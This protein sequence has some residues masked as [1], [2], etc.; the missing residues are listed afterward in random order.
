MFFNNF[1]LLSPNISLYYNKDKS[2]RH[3]SPLGGLLTIIIFILS[4]YIIIKYILL[5]P[6][7][8][9]SSLLMYRNFGIDTSNNYFNESGLFHFIWIYN[10]ENI[11]N[12]NKMQINNLKKGIIRIFMTYSYDKYDYNSQNLKDNDHWVY[13]TCHNYLNKDD[14]KYDYSFS[15]CIKYYYNSIDK[16]YYSIH[17]NL[18]FKWPYIRDNLTDINNK[19]IFSTFIEKCSNN[20]ILNDIMGDCYPEDK[21]N[22]YLSYFNKIFISFNNYK[23]RIN[24]KEIILKDYSDKIYDNI[25]D[26][27]NSFYSRELTFI[28]FNYEAQTNILAKKLRYNSFMLDGER[29]TKIYNRENNNLLLVYIFHFKQYINEFRKQNNYILEFSYQT[30]GTIILIYI[31]FYILNYFLSERIEIRNFQTFLHDKGSN[32]IQKHIHYER[33][34]VFSSKSNN[35]T[36]ISNEPNE[37]YSSFKSTY[38]QKNDIYNSYNNSKINEHNV[39]IKIEKKDDKTISKKSDKN[40]IIVI[41]N[42]TFMN[43]GN[44]SSNNKFNLNIKN[45]LDNNKSLIINKKIK[46]FDKIDEY[47]KT[48]TYTN[49]VEDSPTKNLH[50]PN[51]KNSKII[52]FSIYSKNRNI[53]DDISEKNEILEHSSKQKIIDTSSISLLN[54]INKTKNLYI[55]NSNYNVL[56]KKEIPLLNC[57]KISETFSPKNNNKIHDNNK[58][59]KENYSQKDFISLIKN[60]PENNKKEKSKKNN[61][62]INLIEKY[63]NFKIGSPIRNIKYRRKSHQARNTFREKDEE[64]IDKN[65]T[66][67]NKNK[68]KTGVFQQPQEKKRERKLSLFSRYSNI[69]NSN[70]NNNKTINLYPCENN[71]Q[72]NLSKN[73]L[74]HYKKVN[75]LHKFMAKKVD[76]EK[77]LPDSESQSKN[78]KKEKKIV[79]KKYVTSTKQNNNLSKIIQNINWS[80][81]IFFNYLCMY[82]KKSNNDVNILN[83]FRCKLLSEEYLYILHF[84]MFIFKNKFGCKTNIEAINL[85]EELYND[86]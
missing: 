70:I 21:I 67:K 42:G 86:Y 64:Y 68:Q 10:D 71:S 53:D 50:I 81:K 80:K 16:K 25:I 78:H 66:Y 27:D 3:L 77:P 83:N 35:Y 41:N 48:Y 73:L 79:T 4:L 65:K 45:V 69:I 33:N 63:N 57:D 52:N 56:P 7:P 49:Q 17:D 29:V 44:A 58:S 8:N 76:K 62:E 22:E 14:L 2:K 13:D 31:I 43:D 60:L 47:N 1:D 59:I 9:S 32:T 75:A 24:G 11:I 84:N 38:F 54:V 72:N 46:N 23:F 6:F 15:S 26:N 20:S 34:K 51:R 40:N 37:N 82:K 18:N 5:T 12:N 30:G 74:D 85:M 39:S 36:N 61:K 19:A 28:P 55:D